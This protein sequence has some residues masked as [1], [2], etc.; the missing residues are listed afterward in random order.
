MEKRDIGSNKRAKTNSKTIKIE[1]DVELLKMIDDLKRR[2]C[3]PKE[4]FL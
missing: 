3:L 1:Q 2:G 4:K